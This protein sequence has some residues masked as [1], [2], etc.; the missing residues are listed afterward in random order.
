MAAHLFEDTMMEL[1]YATRLLKLGGVL[2]MHDTNMPSVKATMAFMVSNLG[3]VRVRT[4]PVENAP[5]S[6][7]ILATFVKTKHPGQ[8]RGWMHFV[9]FATTGSW[10]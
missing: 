8:D 7:K 10:N 3:F 5:M 6:N 4:P 9:P 2:V 1:W